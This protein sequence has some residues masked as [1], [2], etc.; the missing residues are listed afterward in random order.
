M[1]NDETEPFERRLSRQPTREIPTHWRAEILSAAQAAGPQPSTLDPR[2]SLL[3]TLIAQL[4]AILRPHP[5]AWAGLAAAWV[6]ILTLQLASRDPTEVVARNTPP[7]SPEL[8]MVLRQQ[9]LLLAELVE[10]PEPRAAEQ[11]KALPLRPRS[12]R[13]HKT[14]T[15]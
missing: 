8:L 6:L 13:Y 7:P 14:F 10:R 11:P 15:A 2:P 5:Q 1:M 9:K 4:L 12:D 3:S